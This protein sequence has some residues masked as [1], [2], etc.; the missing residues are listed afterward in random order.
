MDKGENCW[1]VNAEEGDTIGGPEGRAAEE[2]GSR[3]KRHSKAR[4]LFPLASLKEGK[5][6][7]G[8]GGEGRR[9]LDLRRRSSGTTQ[10]YRTRN[11]GRGVDREKGWKLGKGYL[12]K[13]ERKP[14]NFLQRS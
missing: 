13:D 12:I 11:P 9:Q 10:R 7:V 6:S 4:S 14:R 3:G 5:R 2:R 8:D 1:G